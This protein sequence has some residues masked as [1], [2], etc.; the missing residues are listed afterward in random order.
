MAI[1]FGT[2]TSSSS[3]FGSP[4]MTVRAEK[5][6][7]LPIRLPCKRPSLPLRRA[8]MAS[9]GHVVFAAPREYS[10][11]RYPCTWQC[12][13]RVWRSYCEVDVRAKYN[14]SNTSNQA[15]Q[16]ISIHFH[17]ITRD[18][19]LIFGSRCIA[20]IQYCPLVAIF[21][22]T[23]K[24]LDTAHVHDLQAAFSRIVK[25]TVLSFCSWLGACADGS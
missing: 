1:L 18:V 14:R 17:Y 3:K 9:T 25:Y 21:H 15:Y 10:P 6:T 22:S 20:A 12:V 2:P 24:A 11:C 4:V 5:S 7:R 23:Y 8:R 19:S 16:G 13:W